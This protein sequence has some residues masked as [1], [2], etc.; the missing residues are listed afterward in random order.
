MKKLVAKFPSGHDQ[1][2]QKFS[3]RRRVEEKCRENSKGAFI[4]KAQ[5][6]FLG[7]SA[8]EERQRAII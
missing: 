6:N 7:Q 3:L 1:S 8:A 5:W 4:E 2:A